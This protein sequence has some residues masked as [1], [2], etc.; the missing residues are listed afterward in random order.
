MGIVTR[1]RGGLGHVS[2]LCLRFVCVIIP[3]FSP[4]M[5]EHVG[6]HSGGSGEAVLKRS[7]P[8]RRQ[9]F[10]QIPNHF[11]SSR[12]SVFQSPSSDIPEAVKLYI[13]L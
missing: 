6:I 5:S 11:G 1:Q 2:G 9:L 3:S 7:P 12:K 4:S 10:L 13:L 8:R